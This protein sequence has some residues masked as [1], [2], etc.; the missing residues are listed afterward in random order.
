MIRFGI[1]PEINAVATILL[2][3]TMLSMVTA[4]LVIGRRGSRT[5]MEEVRQ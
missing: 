2:S 1:T 5:R 3:V 4:T